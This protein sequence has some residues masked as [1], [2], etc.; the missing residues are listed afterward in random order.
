MGQTS[1]QQ[2]Q[3]LFMV[4]FMW[5]SQSYGLSQP[6]TLP[7]HSSQATLPTYVEAPEQL[8]MPLVSAHTDIDAPRQPYSVD[9]LPVPTLDAPCLESMD[10][11]HKVHDNRNEYEE[12]KIP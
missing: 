12:L 10:A 8:H 5:W 7:A 9:V 6:T 1:C 4:P 2:V 11:H 3:T